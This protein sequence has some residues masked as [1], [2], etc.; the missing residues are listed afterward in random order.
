MARGLSPSRLFLLKVCAMLHTLLRPEPVGMIGIDHMAAPA[1]SKTFLPM[2]PM[3]GLLEGM[4]YLAI[5]RT[6]K[7]IVIATIRSA[8]AF[9]VSSPITFPVYVTSRTLL[10]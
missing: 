2:S 10:T 4:L 5:I 7:M 1:K 8:K 3:T 6:R 9:L